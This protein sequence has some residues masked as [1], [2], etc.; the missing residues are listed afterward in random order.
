MSTFI[1]PAFS[2]LNSGHALYADIHRFIVLG[3]LDRE[4]VTDTAI[5]IAGAAVVSDADIGS[6][7]AIVAGATITETLNV[8]S[9]STIL[10]I[11]AGRGPRS[12]GGAAACD[13][14]FLHLNTS[15][16][17]VFFDYN[18]SSGGHFEFRYEGGN[19]GVVSWDSDSFAS[20]GAFNTGIAVAATF[21]ETVDR[22]S[23]INGVIGTP[24][25]SG[26]SGALAS[27][28]LT[29]LPG[30]IGTSANFP[31]GA[32][33]V[34]DKILSD[35]ELQS[36]TTDPWAML[37][38]APALTSVDTDDILIDG[39][40]NF[41]A[42]VTNI[43]SGEVPTGARIGSSAGVGGTSLTGFSAATTASAG[44]FICTMD[45]ASGIVTGSTSVASELSI[46]YG[47]V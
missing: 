13:C 27:N 8:P 5:T 17:A 18:Y 33:V 39:Q 38:Q 37:A 4:L 16:N 14:E 40:Q 23:C 19:G 24:L 46:D 12:T 6:A 28:D 20:D 2:G 32:I 25:G 26:T 47:S 9:N 7:R 36:V 34:F 10:L 3:S 45:L 42:T 43:P 44:E 30:V 31:V 41:T 1:K 35:A 15:A 21:A 11:T 22:K 29:L